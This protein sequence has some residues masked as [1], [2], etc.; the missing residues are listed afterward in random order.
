MICSTADPAIPKRDAD[1][2]VTGRRGVSSILRL[3]LPVFVVLIGLGSWQVHRLY[4][5]QALIATIA[6]RA[7][8]PP[9]PFNEI[10][11]EIG[12]YSEGL[13]A[14]AYR[15][16]T[17]TGSY[18]DVQTQRLTIRFHNGTPGA[19]LVTPLVLTEGRAVLVDRGWIPDGDVTP[20]PPADEA[21]TVVGIVRVPEPANWITPENDPA[22]GAW[23]WLDLDALARATGYDVAPIVIADAASP[24]PGAYPIPKPPSP[25]LPNNHLQYVLTWYGL[26]V[27]LLVV[28]LVYER[29]RRRAGTR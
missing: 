9:V 1:D 23:H 17:A 16:V 22:R 5:K 8:L 27:A 24:S 29:G 28:A 26:A 4:W 21:Q 11:S 15:R 12:A 18:D 3:V 20:P 6:A 19:H 7:D 25:N 2:T 14:V 13:E 10:L